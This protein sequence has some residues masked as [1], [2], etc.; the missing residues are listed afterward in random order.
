MRYLTN[1]LGWRHDTFAYRSWADHRGN[2]LGSHFCFGASHQWQSPNHELD[3]FAAEPLTIEMAKVWLGRD[4][5]TSLISGHGNGAGWLT[6]LSEHLDLA[7]LPEFEAIEDQKQTGFLLSDSD[8][9]LRVGFSSTARVSTEVGD[10]QRFIDDLPEPELISL[11]N[12]EP[13]LL[14][15]Y[16]HFLRKLN[17]V[18]AIHWDAGL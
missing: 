2:Q 10:S 8:V 1:Q 13:H 3:L 6:L 18:S 4:Q 7:D 5:Y 14:R 11:L 15:F 12:K 16:L 9:V 17:P